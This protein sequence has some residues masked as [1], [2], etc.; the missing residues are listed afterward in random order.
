MK[1]HECLFRAGAI[2]RL[3]ELDGD[4][5][6]QADICPIL[7]GRHIQ[8]FRGERLELPAKGLIKRSAEHV[9]QSGWYT[10]FVGG[11]SGEWFGRC[12]NVDR[13][14]DPLARAFNWRVEG[15]RVGQPV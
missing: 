4:G 6:F 10:D 3:A 13:R 8:N 15:E 11:S 1:Q 14:V 5:C 7:G 2:H 12:E 9:A